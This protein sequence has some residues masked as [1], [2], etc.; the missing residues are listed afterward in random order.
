MRYESDLQKIAFR[1]DNI[2]IVNVTR[3]KNYRNSYKSGRTHNGFIYTVRGRIRNVFFSSDMDEIETSAGDLVFVPKGTSYVS[4]YL[5]D[6][7]ELKVVH[8]DLF[9]GELPEYLSKP[10]KIDLPNVKEIM[11][12]FFIPRKNPSVNHPLYYLSRLYDLLWQLEKKH[13]RVPTKYKKLKPAL[14]DIAEH[15]EKN[16]PISDYAELCDMSEVNFRRLFREYTGTSPIDYR[17]GMRL[18]SAKTKLQS[19]EYNVS[20]AAESV[21]FSNLSFFIRLYKKKFGYT[22]KKE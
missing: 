22:P 18:E 1:V 15:Y 3:N 10:V 16:R 13:A 8:F 17:N 14:H 6:D 11:D 9:S 2:I 5:E 4:T 12:S 21:G 20:E 19:G 7:T